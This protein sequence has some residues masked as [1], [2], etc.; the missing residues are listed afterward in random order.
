MKYLFSLFWKE[1]YVLH[2]RIKRL[3]YCMHKIITS[4]LTLFEIELEFLYIIAIV[5]ISCV[6]KMFFEKEHA[7]TCISIESIMLIPLENKT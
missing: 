4:M 7:F 2:A 5:N 1:I 3:C 6:E